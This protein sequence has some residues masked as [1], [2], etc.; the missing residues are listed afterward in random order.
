VDVDFFTPGPAPPESY[1]L[2]VSALVPYKRIDIAV[3]AANRLG[4]R[5]K[6]VGSGPD[7]MRLRSIAG[8]TVEFTGSL[9][10]T[11]LRDLYRG[12]QALVLP[13]EEDF[14]IAPVESMACGRPVIALARGGATETIEH[15]VTGLLVAEPSAEAF[16]AAMRSAGGR[17]WSADEL[18]A[19]AAAYGPAAFDAGF[20]QIVAETVAEMAPC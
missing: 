4:T 15:D 5:L 20:R 14:G 11:R 3:Q 7:L 2:V 6:I 9:D 1:F 8:P 16:A 10:A 13:A 19:R 12:T 17:S 18:S